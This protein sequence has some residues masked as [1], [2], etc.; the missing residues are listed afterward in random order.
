MVIGSTVL[1][2]VVVNPPR[3]GE[4]GPFVALF[5]G[6]IVVAL[7]GVLATRRVAKRTS[8]ET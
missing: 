2:F 6:L 3:P 8:T 5:A 4:S 1:A 7:L